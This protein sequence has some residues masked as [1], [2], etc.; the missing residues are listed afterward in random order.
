MGVSLGIVVCVMTVLMRVSAATVAEQPGAPEVHHQADNGDR[1]RL[2]EGDGHRRAQPLESLDGDER[3]GQAE[4]DGAGEAR[5]IAELAGAEGEAR[6]V[7]VAARQPVGEDA[8]AERRDMRPHVPAIGQQREGAEHCSGDD[9][10]DHG[11]GGDDDDREG[12]AAVP[13]VVHAQDVFTV[14]RR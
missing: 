7:R 2:A 6:V 14:K 3:G 9:L 4:R 5:E 10:G 8:D 12:A 1:Q 13:V 11:D